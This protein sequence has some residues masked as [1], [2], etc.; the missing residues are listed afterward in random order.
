MKMKKWIKR[1]FLIIV[2]LLV[3]IVLCI[4]SLN[5][6]VTLHAKKDIVDSSQELSQD[7]D[8]ILI[9][10]AGLN[11]GKPSPMLTDRLN[12]GISLYKEGKAPKILMSGDHGSEYYNEVKVMKQY[13]MDAGVPSS[14]IF[15]DH[16]G[17]STY[18]SMWRA[19]NV[20]SVSKPIIVTQ[21]YHLYRATYIAQKSGLNCT[22]IPS[23]EYPY[24]GKPKRLIREFLARCK[25]VI[26][27]AVESPPSY[28]GDK[29]PITGDGNETND[30]DFNKKIE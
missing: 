20:F 25:D 26:T 29:I 15:M 22:G 18:E 12:K 5:L 30:L 11:N 3:F 8:C 2:L 16:A 17:F 4:L 14:D 28:K 1:I 13:A 24:G 9:L 21:R 23:D 7:Y 6:W 10:G 27:S 19:K